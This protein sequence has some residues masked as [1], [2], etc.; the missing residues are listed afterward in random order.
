LDYSD[1]A[2]SVTGPEFSWPATAD[3]DSWAV[4]F[5]MVAIDEAAGRP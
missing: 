5:Y 1:G 2:R 4:R 3:F